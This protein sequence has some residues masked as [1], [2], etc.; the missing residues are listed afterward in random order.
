MV[1]CLEGP[2][3]IFNGHE[4]IQDKYRVVG[5]IKAGLYQLEAYLMSL[6]SG[7]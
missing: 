2:K 3:A 5:V 1:R 4:R 6:V 7:N